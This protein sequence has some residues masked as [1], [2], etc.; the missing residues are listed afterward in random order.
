M[1]LVFM[2]N[3]NRT[4]S[5][6]EANA[7]SSRSHAVL[8]INICQRLKTADVSED[9]TVATLS[10]IDLAGSERASATKNRGNRL[11]EGTGDFSDIFV[12]TKKPGIMLKYTC[13]H[14]SLIVFY[15]ARSKYQ[16][17][18]ACSWKLHQCT[19]RQ[20]TQSTYPLSRQQTHPPSQVLSR[21]KLQDGHDCLCEP[22]K[23]ALRGNSQHIEIRQPSQ[24]HQDQGDQKHAE[25]RPPRLRICPGNLRAETRGCR[26][27]GKAPQPSQ[28][29]GDRENATKTGHDRQTVRGNNT[30]DASYIS[31]GK[32]S[33]DRIRPGAGTDVHYL[34][35]IAGVEPVASRLRNGI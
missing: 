19:L 20:Q 7:T 14:G 1:N 26:A 22:V 27:Q 23:P 35:S 21:W 30:K 18:S 24:E 9:F 13:S 6:T 10:L 33:R 3:A 11:I 34:G 32:D 25:R 28:E 17:V 31:G 8:Q 29:R 4:M 16:Q 15:Y 5:P 12:G 2:G